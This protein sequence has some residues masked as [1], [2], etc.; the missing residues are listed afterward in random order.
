MVSP[1]GGGGR[2]GWRAAQRVLCLATIMPRSFPW[3]PPPRTDPMRGGVKGGVEVEGKGDGEG[4]KVRDRKIRKRLPRPVPDLK[5]T[6]PRRNQTNI[7]VY[8]R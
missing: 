6:L 1:S 8:A 2:R 5:H 3:T 4:E 7:H